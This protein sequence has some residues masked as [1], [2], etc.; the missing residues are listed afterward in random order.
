MKVDHIRK[1]VIYHMEVDG[2]CYK[3]YSANGWVKTMFF[4]IMSE[5]YDVNDKVCVELEELFQEFKD[6][7][8]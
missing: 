6:L 7:A 2:G 5:D 4:D 3:R 8:D 1:E